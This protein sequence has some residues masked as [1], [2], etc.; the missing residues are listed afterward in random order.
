MNSSRVQWWMVGGLAL[1]AGC[2]SSSLPV[3]EDGRDSGTP[4][5]SARV[6][7]GGPLRRDAGPPSKRD[8]GGS[9]PDAVAVD[10]HVVGDTSRPTPD[11]GR[12]DAG[13]DARSP[14]PDSSSPPDA[15]ADAGTCAPPATDGG[16]WPYDSP[17]NGSLVG[18]DV[19]GQICNLAASV[20]TNSNGAFFELG[21]YQGT[22]T[23]Q[24]SNPSDANYP[25]VDALLPISAVSPGVYT[26]S[27]AVNCGNIEVDYGLPSPPGLVCT[28]TTPPM[29]PSGC[30]S[31][32]SGLGCEPCTP[33]PPEVDYSASGQTGGICSEVYQQPGTLSGSWTITLT[34]VAQY[35]G[36]QPSQDATYYTVHG[37]FTA[38]VIGGG[39]GDGGTYPATLSVD[40]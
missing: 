12:R 6:D 25:I 15:R 27:D 7:T 2:S 9:M 21:S 13:S 4:D 33:N 17:A 18:P 11:A 30:N 32:C 20:E 38:D 1:A 3:V 37:H 40:F 23:I 5:G 14:K 35:T 36:S 8:G 29:C 19:S 10:S 26:S 28:G 39:D 31:A 16:F 34:S 24:F 22:S